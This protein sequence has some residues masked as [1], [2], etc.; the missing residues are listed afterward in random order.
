MSRRRAFIVGCGRIAGGY[1]RDARSLV[2]THV[3][4]YQRLGVDV[5]GCCDVDEAR[6][7]RFAE[8]WDIPRWGTDLRG[9]LAD[10]IP[11]LVSD[12]TPPGS[13]A[14]VFGM[15]QECP[16]VR[17]MV[18]EKPLGLTAADARSIAASL[19]ASGIRGVVNYHRAFDPFYRSLANGVA[20]ERAGRLLA[21][22]CLYYGAALTNA[23][24]LLERVL[25]MMGPASSTK[26]LSGSDLAPCFEVALES[27]AVATFTPAPAA[28]YAPLEMDLFF[29][30]A[31]VRVLDSERRVERFGLTPDPVFPG[32]EMLSRQSGPNAGPTVE[33][34]ALVFDAVAN[35][36]LDDTGL[37]ARAVRVTELLEQ[38]GAVAP[39]I[40]ATT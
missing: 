15:V 20:P 1:N 18:I 10:A 36:R 5:V 16:T 21:V 24:H 6:A 8:D 39:S 40:E 4:A 33:A 23:S 28:A 7:R 26:R 29:E 30:R 13:R 38:V 34:L 19:E 11:D 27:G 14:A 31:R 2:L 32:F 17:Q 25:A 35:D 22:T 9:L 37:I 3:L 12:C